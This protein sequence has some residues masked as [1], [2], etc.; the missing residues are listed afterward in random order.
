MKSGRNGRLAQTQVEFDVVA[1]NGTNAK[2]MGYNSK[3]IPH[4]QRIVRPAIV[5]KRIENVGM[6]DFSN[7]EIRLKRMSNQ[8]YE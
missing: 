5:G 4:A 1:K 7:D 2:L 6:L 8:L 3:E